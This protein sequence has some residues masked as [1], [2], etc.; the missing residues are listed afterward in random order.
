MYGHNNNGTAHVWSQLAHFFL[1]WELFQRNC[2]RIQNTNLMF[3]NL[4][5]FPPRKSFRLW[6]SVVK[7]GRVRQSTDGNTI[8]RMY[9]ACWTTNAAD[10]HTEYVTLIAFP[11][12]QWLR[13]RASALRL[14][15]HCLYMAVVNRYLNTLSESG[16]YTY[17]YFSIPCLPGLWMTRAANNNHSGAFCEGKRWS[18]LG[19]GLGAT[20]WSVGGTGGMAPPILKLRT[21]SRCQFHE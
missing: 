6:H 10:T 13:E 2:R 9:F 20:L 19:V 7:C 8:Q 17:Q 15:V 11:H 1:E 3:S 5:F 18:C 12:Q 21:R 14:Y 16:N 4:L